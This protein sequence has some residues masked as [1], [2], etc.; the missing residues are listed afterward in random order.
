MDNPEGGIVVENSMWGVLEQF[1]SAQN[2]DDLWIK[3]RQHLSVYG[4]SSVFYG[5]THSP[6]KLFISGAEELMRYKTDHTEKF[7][8]YFD[9][10]F[11]MVDDIT[12]VHCLLHE[13]SYLWHKDGQYGYK[14]SP[15]QEAFLGESAEFGMGVGVTVPLRFGMG[16]A[17][18]MGLC[19]EGMSA[20]EFNL[21]WIEHSDQILGACKLFDE[22]ARDNFTKEMF[23]LT[24]REIEVLHW[25]A[26]GKNIK[27]IADKLGTASSTVDKQ[28][29]T[30][31][32]KLK[33]R[34][35]EQAVLKAYTLGLIA[36]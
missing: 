6:R 9:E 20:K 28:V 21:I 3:M 35:N 8:D 11:N 27:F 2:L 33:S 4:I 29:R 16:G 36:P 19:N 31:R 14:L 34:N 30:A 22:C 7:R 17:G 15:R 24:F 18:G 1:N 32:G 12:A 25:L 23:T 26:E 10:K 13:S 5:V